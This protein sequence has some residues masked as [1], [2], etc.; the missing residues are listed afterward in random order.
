MT[1]AR[2]REPLMPDQPT[3]S[4]TDDESEN[5]E[6]VSTTGTPRWVKVF[7]MIALAL[8]LLLVI[9]QFVGG[10]G[11]GPRRHEG[12]GNQP[13]ASISEEAGHTRP[14]GIDHGG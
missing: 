9:L 3:H 5:V 12:H 4:D 8:V 2:E 1:H 6:P 7:G 14:L 13:A 10:G 11:H